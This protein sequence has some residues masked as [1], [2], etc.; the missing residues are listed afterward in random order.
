LRV[1]GSTN[2]A[3][4]ILE[5]CKIANQMD[6][7]MDV[8]TR[9]ILFTDGQANRGPATTKDELL[10]LSQANAGI[11][12]FSAFGYGADAQQDMLLAMAK[13][14]NGN[15][16]FVE[17]PDD[18]LT[19]F[20]QELG[21]LLSTY[22][23][24]LMVE[25]TPLA[26]HKITKVVSDVDAEE[27][28]LGQMTIKIP[29]LLSEETRNVVLEVEL[30]SQASSGPRAV[31]VFET[32][33]GYDTLNANLHKEHSLLEAKA[34]VRFVKSGEQQDAPDSEL[35]RI[36]GLAQVVRAQIEAEEFAQ[37][38]D[39]NQAASV[40]NLIGAVVNSRGLGDLSQ[41][42][43]GISDKMSSQESYGANTAYLA[44]F[45]RGATR[46]VGG[47]YCSSAA[48]DLQTMGVALSTSAQDHVSSLFNA[49]EDG[50]SG[51]PAGEVTYGDNT[52]DV[53]WV[54]TPSVTTDMT[55][56]T[57]S[58]EYRPP[59]LVVAEDDVNPFTGE[60]E[61]EPKK[62]PAK[63]RPKKISQKRRNW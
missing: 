23:T 10:K 62:E 3:D 37:Q 11:A 51:E 21:G 44:S 34:K 20:G 36:V 56:T 43:Q 38:G 15:Y 30:Q 22:A 26:G 2:I 63:K 42:A 31:N 52:G 9:V 24:N 59:L 17:S 40:M 50:D 33:V 1:I 54:V 8:L 39:Y 35:D 48:A 61:A 19:A 27:G 49:P 13:Q 55:W 25:V 58:G 4:A 47:T 6:L 60:K 57:T 41:V 45:T 7:S 29:D 46:G 5:G 32:R 14:G 28:A 18:A 16:A 12:S 53:S